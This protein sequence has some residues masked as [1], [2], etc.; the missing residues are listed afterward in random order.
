MKAIKKA[1]IVAVVKDSKI[2]YDC[3]RLGL[4]P[5]KLFRFYKRAG[6]PESKIHDIQTSHDLQQQGKCVINSLFAPEQVIS[7]GSFRP[8]MLRNRK[9]VVTFGGDNH[10]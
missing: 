6:Y 5:L 3:R 10:L 1:E 2:D 9:L 7:R 8:V 4:T